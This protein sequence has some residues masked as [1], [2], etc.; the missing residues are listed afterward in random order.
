MLV[1]TP[2]NLRKQWS[3]EVEE[4]FILPTIILEARN[5]NKM[6]KDGLRRPFEQKALVI[7]SYQFAAR[8]ADELMVIPMAPLTS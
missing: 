6:K 5:S 2:A 1:I 8:H 3:Q 4:K 7:C